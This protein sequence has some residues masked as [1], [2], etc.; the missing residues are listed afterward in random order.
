[1][2]TNHYSADTTNVYFFG[3]ACLDHQR[4]AEMGENL[5]IYLKTY[6]ETTR[7][8]ISFLRMER[9]CLQQLVVC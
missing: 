8:K 5:N 4:R 6:K 7:R 2:K 1:M 9:A 3:T